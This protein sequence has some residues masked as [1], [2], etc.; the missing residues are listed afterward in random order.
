VQY[1]LERLPQCRYS[2]AGYQ[3][4]DL[5]ANVKFQP[6]GLLVTRPV[7]MVV[8]P[9]GA[10]PARIAVPVEL[11]VPRGTQSV[12]LWFRNF[13]AERCEAWD[14]N[15]GHN[16]RFG[17]AAL[18]APVGWAG[19]WGGSFARDCQHRDGLAEP[20]VIDEYVRERAC[21]W[22]DADAWVPGLTDGP[23]PHPER[24]W[25]EV[26][27]STDGAPAEHAPLR[28]VERAGNNGRYRWELPYPVLT[29]AWHTFAFRF[30]FSSDGNHWVAIGQ[31][32][33]SPRTVVRSFGTP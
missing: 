24:L 6:Q 14:S 13:D 31:P 29:E 32:D 19:D 16:Y 5:E 21:K 25:A 28:L 22:V 27:W 23:D 7:T 20:I 17:A 26:E 33:G 4:W 15:W 1:A 30:R 9:G 2:R 18:P 12:E 8:T 3:L 11:D 10:G